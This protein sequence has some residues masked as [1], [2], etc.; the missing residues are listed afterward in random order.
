MDAILTFFESFKRN[1]SSAATPGKSFA[2]FFVFIV[3][4]S[5]KG[6]ETEPWIG[7]EG[8]TIVYRPDVIAFA[9]QK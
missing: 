6:C 5:L 7:F 8:A 1:N 9:R 3:I 2:F 4:I